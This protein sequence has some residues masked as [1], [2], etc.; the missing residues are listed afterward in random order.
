M[1][2]PTSFFLPSLVYTASEWPP[3]SN[4]LLIISDTPAELITFAVTLT[5]H[6]SLNGRHVL[7]TTQDRDSL[8]ASLNT[9]TLLTS[10]LSPM[11]TTRSILASDAITVYHVDTLSQLRILLSSLQHSKVGFLGVD[12][13]VR[14]H[15]MAVE[16]SAQGISR[17]LAAIVNIISSSNGSLV[18]REPRYSVERSVPIL[19]S[20][21]NS[22][23]LS[24]ATVPITRILGRWV[25]GFWNQESNGEG[26]CSAEWV[27][28]GEKWNIRWTL[29]DGEIGDVQISKR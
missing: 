11:S 2:P 17:T 3:T 9:S 4:P 27:C 24:H 26:D 8:I 16:L 14:L 15:D 29:H 5:Q 21:V 28:Q 10:P 12:N 19:N 18:L 20:G 22:G 6:S 7:I 13:F 1:T 23:G 25:R